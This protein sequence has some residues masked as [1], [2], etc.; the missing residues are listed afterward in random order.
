MK[1]PKYKPK[2]QPF[3]GGITVP[4]ELQS[5]ELYMYLLPLVI[6]VLFVLSMMKIYST[7]N[8]LNLYTWMILLLAPILVVSAIIYKFYIFIPK[9]AFFLFWGVL[10]Y[11]FIYFCLWMYHFIDTRIYNNLDHIIGWCILYAIIFVTLT[12]IFAVLSL[13]ISSNFAVELL[14]FILYL[15][16]LFYD[17]V[18]NR[19]GATP[20][21]SIVFLLW[22]EVALIVGYLGYLA[23]VNQWAPIASSLNWNGI[24]QMQPD[25]YDLSTPAE[26]ILVNSSYLSLVDPEYQAN[27]YTKVYTLSMWV[28]VNPTESTQSHQETNL[29]YYG[30]RELAPVSTPT[31][32]L[33]DQNHVRIGGGG[34]SNNH[35]MMPPSIRDATE[36]PAPPDKWIIVNP[37][38]RVSY[39]YDAKDHRDYYNVYL[40]PSPKPTYRINIPNQKWNQFIFVFESDHVDL[41]I[42]GHLDNSWRHA[43][44]ITTQFAP[45]D[46]IAIG[47]PDSRVQGSMKMITYYD[48]AFTKDQAVDLWNVERVKVTL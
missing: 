46:V 29:L 47:D 12:L 10:A 30:S 45:Q 34:T 14:E 8:L 40:T 24:L 41:Y 6:F 38:P 11:F 48:R 39:I 33:Y 3:R 9:L 1:T 43:D 20:S 28:Y 25:G 19:D 32:S 4:Q 16:S 44:G 35:V 2:S 26:N 13:F 37:K 27:P 22:L 17:F 5:A 36:A 18:Q 31:P 15:P 21:G 23:V 42:N 7:G